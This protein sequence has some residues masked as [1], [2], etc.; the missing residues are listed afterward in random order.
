MTVVG[1]H[2]VPVTLLVA[3]RHRFGL[4]LLA[5]SVGLAA[6]MW[7]LPALDRW[8]E[9]APWVAGLGVLAY[10]GSALS[11]Y[12][13]GRR[14]SDVETT[15]TEEEEVERPADFD[16]LVREALEQL[17][18]L[19]GLSESKL[20]SYLPSTLAA[21]QSR[22]TV[23]TPPDTAPLSQ[24]RALREALLSALGRLRPANEP[25]Q[26]SSPGLVLY[27]VINDRYVLQR[28]V[29]HTITRLNISER[30]Y[31]RVRNSGVLAIASDLW[32]R[33]QQLAGGE[34]ATTATPPTGQAGR[35]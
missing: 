26:G 4:I 8:S 15:D 12:W 29:T 6:G 16:G 13:T 19:V 1:E 3:L 32:H 22:S 24:A 33:E 17:N 27:N 10:A 23:A 21:V 2:P 9:M 35:R 20:I 11:V 28:P 7:F 34:P 30:A 25:A 18:N 31:H 14:P 5:L